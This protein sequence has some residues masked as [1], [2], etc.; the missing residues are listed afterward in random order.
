MLVCVQLLAV[1]MVTVYCKLFAHNAPQTYRMV[2]EHNALPTV[3]YS[4]EVTA[5]AM[6]ECTAVV[7][8]QIG[9]EFWIH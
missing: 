7:V 2:C 6:F 1:A 9:N 4:T 8:C 5:H 3:R